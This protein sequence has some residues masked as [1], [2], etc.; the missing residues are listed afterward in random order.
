MGAATPSCT[1]CGAIRVCS[2]ERALDP[3]VE[4]MP[5]Q[6]LEDYW[7]CC[8]SVTHPL[9]EVFGQPH[10]GCTLPSSVWHA[11]VSFLQAHSVCAVD[12]NVLYISVP[13]RRQ[14]PAQVAH[15][16]KAPSKVRRLHGFRLPGCLLPY[17][18]SRLVRLSLTSVLWPDAPPLCPATF[19][20]GSSRV[21][22][23]P[24]PL[25]GR[26]GS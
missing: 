24:S 16:C 14:A 19:P 1:F 21:V 18:C 17:N 5:S 10:D 23:T 8:K 2:A 11:M 25:Q 15:C 12:M 26:G 22:S 7:H 13:I 3:C 20:C 6:S 9:H 4:D